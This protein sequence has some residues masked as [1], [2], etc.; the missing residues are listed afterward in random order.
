V[1]W[2]GGSGREEFDGVKDARGAFFWHVELVAAVMVHCW[3]DVPAGGSVGRPGGA[4]TRFFVP[5]GEGAG[6]CEWCCV[7]IKVAVELRIRGEFGVEAR[8]AEEVQ[9][10]V[11]LAD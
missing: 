9:G 8:G 2:H 3:T 5:D 4:I 10:D 11:G 6:R 7:V 1:A